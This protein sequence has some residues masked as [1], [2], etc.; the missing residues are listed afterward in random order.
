MNA[1]AYLTDLVGEEIKTITGRTNRV[2]AVVG[3]D[4]VVA[5]ARSPAG[6]PVP[7][8]WVQQAMDQLEQVGE[9]TIDVETVGYRS[10]FIGAVLSTLPGAVVLPTSPPRIRHG[11]G[12]G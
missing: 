6:Q 8:A 10:A 1:R 2:L 11:G 7:I 3:G 12:D 5:T 9:I 4:V